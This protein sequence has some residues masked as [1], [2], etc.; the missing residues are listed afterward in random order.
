VSRLNR[1]YRDARARFEADPAFADRSRRRVVA[2]QA[3]DPPTLAAWRAIV[4]ESTR[5]FTQVYERLDVLLTDADVAGESSY[6]DRLP[7]VAA[8]LAAAGVAVPSHGALCVFFD[9]VRSPDGMPV[10]LIVRKSDGGYGYAATDL[11]ALRHRVDPL[12]ADRILYVVDARQA[13]HFRMVFDTARRAGWLPDRVAAYHLPFRTVLGPDGRPFRT[14]AGE[15]T[16]LVDLLDAAV[17]RARAVVAEK[18]PD[19]DPAAADERARQIGVGAVKYADL[20]TNRTRDYVFDPARMLSLTGD[21]AVYLQFAHARIRSI[22]RRADATAGTGAG[23]GGT[24][25]GTVGVDPSVPLT[26]AERRLAL[27]LDGFADAVTETAG[28]YE[29]HRLCGYLYALAQAYTRFYESCPVLAAPPAVRGN[30]LVLCRLTGQVLRTGL[31]LLGIAA[32]EE[33]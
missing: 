17:D 5:H 4:A 6:N 31:G 18:W 13:L 33:L 28:A 20:S 8:E 25:A 21:T 12:R 1:L 24:G 16:R 7:Q 15:T 14:R 30:R 3:G 29:P 32:P 22:L 26:P 9:D 2:L 10:P 11:A 23:H 27:H 19:L